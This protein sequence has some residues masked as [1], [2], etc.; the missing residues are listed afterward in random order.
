MRT[1]R[2]THPARARRARRRR[3]DA[4]CTSAQN[5]RQRELASTSRHTCQE[6]DAN[7][8]TDGFMDRYLGEIDVEE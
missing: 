8:G 1:M 2:H 5:I 6:T 7:G 3:R 4:A